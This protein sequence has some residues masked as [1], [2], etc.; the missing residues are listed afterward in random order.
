MRKLFDILAILAFSKIIGSILGIFY[1]YVGENKVEGASIFWGY[2]MFIDLAFGVFFVWFYYL[3][4][5]RSTKEK[6]IK[7]FQLF[8][9]GF[10]L[11]LA[12]GYILPFFY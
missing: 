7:I 8:V 4:S 9:A 12:V 6:I 5:Q 1:G 2:S 3:Y 10:V 11:T